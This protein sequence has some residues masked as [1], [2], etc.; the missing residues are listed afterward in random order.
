MLYDREIFLNTKPC[1]SLSNSRL[2]KLEFIKSKELKKVKR[3]LLENKEC[4]YQKNNL[5]YIE[6]FIKIKL[7][8]K[9]HD[10]IFF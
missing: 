5:S 1:V 6:E 8:E 10:L 3:L 4:G 2:H 7:E 9:Q